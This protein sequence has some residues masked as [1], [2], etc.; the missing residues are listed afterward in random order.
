MHKKY[1]VSALPHLVSVNIHTLGSC[2]IITRKLALML[3]TLAL[4]QIPSFYYC[5]CCYYCCYCYSVPGSNSG[6]RIS[7]TCQVPLVFSSQ[8]Q[9]LILS[10]L[11]SVE[12]PEFVSVWH[13]FM[14][15]LRLWI[16]KKSHRRAVVSSLGRLIHNM[17][18][19]NF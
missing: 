2:R 15:R 12:Y 9:F 8:G 16:W 14:V 6:S 11:V 4:T 18:D 3:L 19:I 1:T 10:F 13:F 17:W 7:C 5:C